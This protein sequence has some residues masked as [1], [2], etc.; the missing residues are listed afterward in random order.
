MAVL[1]QAHPTLKG[2]RRFAAEFLFFGLKQAR[3]CLF[4]GLFFAA[5]FTV[6]QAGL[7]GIPRYDLLLII[8]L[9]IQIWMVVT[10][11]ETVDEL[12]AI[13]L[14]HV[15]G[16]ALELFKPRMPF[17]RGAIRISATQSS[18]AY[19]CFPGSCTRAL[20]V[21]SFRPGDLTI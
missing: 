10:R 16:L 15:I 6:P 3:A 18:S 7:F 4:V 9:V 20:V 14:F 11:L 5:V 17:D 8:A 21:M 19:H 2:F 12:K 1:D 13:T